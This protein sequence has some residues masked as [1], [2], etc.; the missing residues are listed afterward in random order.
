MNRVNGKVYIGSSID[1]K[2]RW[3][4]HKATLRKSKH[5]N[6]KLQAAWNKYGEDSFDFC[7]VE[8]CSRDGLIAREQSWIDSCDCVEV[9]YNLNPVAGNMLGFKHSEE[10]KEAIR[11]AMVGRDTSEET[12]KL[13]SELMTGTTVGDA[14]RAKISETMKKV[15]ASDPNFQGTKNLN[16]TGTK[17]TPEQIAKRVEA[18]ARTKALKKLL[19]EAGAS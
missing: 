14:T 11:V 13:R 7:V 19:K 12:R 16:R 15:A 4:K 18:T 17:Q 5:A 2:R 10:T 6:A 9:G 3:Y 8:E 1:I